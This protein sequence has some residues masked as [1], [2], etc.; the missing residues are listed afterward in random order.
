MEPILSLRQGVTAELARWLNAPILL[1]TNV[2]GMARSV[3]ALV[4]GYRV[5]KREL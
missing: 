2:H 3:A 1:V 4:K 5:S